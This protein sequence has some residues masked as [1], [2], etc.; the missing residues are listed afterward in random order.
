VNFIDNQVDPKTGNI[1]FRI[2]F[3]NPNGLL[4]PGQYVTLQVTSFELEQALIVPQNIVQEDQG[5][6][7][8]LVVD[9]EEKV[10]AQYVQLGERLDENWV[11][12]SGLEEGQR[13]ITS[14]LQQARPGNS[15]TAN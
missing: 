7:Y 14:G 8:V 10:Q 6:R 12:Q 11:V 13:L 3:D 5:G 9:N 1:T 4:L 2:K 15:V